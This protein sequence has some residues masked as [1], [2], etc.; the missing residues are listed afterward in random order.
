MRARLRNTR[1][2]ASGLGV[3]AIAVFSATPVL[4]SGGPLRTDANAVTN[5]YATFS[6]P[7][8]EM[9]L[10]YAV[11]AFGTYPGGTAAGTD[12]SGGTRYVYAYQAYTYRVVRLVAG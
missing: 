5:G 11:F 12:P 3:L 10:D 6:K 7:G 8:F 1:S 4:G 2:L 9:E